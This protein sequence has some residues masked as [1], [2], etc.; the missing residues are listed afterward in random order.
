MSCLASESWSELIV[1][2]A[3]IRARSA[4]RHTHTHSKSIRTLERSSTRTFD[5]RLSRQMSV[6][7]DDLDPSSHR[8]SSQFRI[9]T[10][11]VEHE[12]L[13]ASG[14][15]G[16]SDANQH[17]HASYSD[18]RRQRPSIRASEKPISE[19]NVQAT[20]DDEREFCGI[21]RRQF[22][23][24]SNRAQTK[25]TQFEIDRSIDRSIRSRNEDEERG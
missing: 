17:S 9:G 10:H 24:P 2:L 18:T 15:V 25:A 16:R 20:D 1:S 6:G 11:Q 19:L 4:A 21:D 23:V 22:R 3:P 8:F 14:Q 13:P 12:V 5:P 7:N